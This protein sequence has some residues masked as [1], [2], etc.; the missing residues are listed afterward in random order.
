MTLVAFLKKCAMHLS[1]KCT[2]NVR[3]SHQRRSFKKDILKN[4]EKF[5]RK[6]LCWSLFF[7]KIALKKRIQHKFFSCKFCE[8]FKKMFLIENLQEIAFQTFCSGIQYIQYTYQND[9]EYTRLIW[10]KQ[11]CISNK[12][13]NYLHGLRIW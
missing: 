1:Y 10:L 3:S 12:V 11:N 5:K 8:I 2:S 4:F 13:E 7:N 6:R 9:V